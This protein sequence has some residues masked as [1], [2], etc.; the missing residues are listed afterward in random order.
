MSKIGIQKLKY[1][2]GGENEESLRGGREKFLN[3]DIGSMGKVQYNS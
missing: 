1:H 2:A 3:K